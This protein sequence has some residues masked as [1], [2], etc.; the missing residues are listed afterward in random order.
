MF[1]QPKN[2]AADSFIFSA[3]SSSTHLQ[4]TS[5]SSLGYSHTRPG[6]NPQRVGGYNNMM[7]ICTLH[8]Y[9]PHIVAIII[10]IHTPPW[11]NCPGMARAE[12][13]DDAA[14]AD[15]RANIGHRVGLA[16]AFSKDCRA[17]QY[18]QRKW[19]IVPLLYRFKL[20]GYTCLPACLA[21]KCPLQVPCNEHSHHHR[22]HLVSCTCICVSQ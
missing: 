22:R 1:H 2:I 9:L 7:W 6:L 20:G 12:T 17:P 11:D 19:G 15:G 16:P 8:S 14:D 18:G 3:C 13:D 10:I 5:P 4:S 21:L